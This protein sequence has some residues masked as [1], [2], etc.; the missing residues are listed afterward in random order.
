MVSLQGLSGAR[1][2]A[3]LPRSPPKLAG[4]ESLAG[5]NAGVLAERGRL[6][7]GE[8]PDPPGGSGVYLFGVW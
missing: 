2:Q 7:L 5:L 6:V 1:A 8:A 3:L 4:G